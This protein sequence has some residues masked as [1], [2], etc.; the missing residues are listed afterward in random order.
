ML[1]D[2][3]K[4]DDRFRKMFFLWNFRFFYRSLQSSSGENIALIA[5]LPIE[6]QCVPGHLDAKFLFNG[7]LDAIKPWVIEFPYL[8]G[9]VVFL[10]CMILWLSMELP[11]IFG[12]ELGLDIDF[13]NNVQYRSKLQFYGDIRF[14]SLVRVNQPLISVSEFG[15][16]E[17]LD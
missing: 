3:L 1:R 4:K 13:W 12:V 16:I 11:F 8:H 7:G 14:C 2:T 17:E 10:N 15:S 9:K 5:A 6:M